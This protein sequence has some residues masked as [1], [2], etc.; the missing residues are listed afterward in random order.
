MKQSCCLTAPAETGASLPGSK[1]SAEVAAAGS[2]SSR[3]GDSSSE[4]TAL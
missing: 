2:A 3:L 1:D 4:A